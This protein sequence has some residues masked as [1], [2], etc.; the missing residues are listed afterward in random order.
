MSWLISGRGREKNSHSL[1]PARLLVHRM[2]INPTERHWPSGKVLF[3]IR[4]DAKLRIH[5]HPSPG[6]CTPYN[7]RHL[8]LPGLHRSHSAPD[9]SRSYTH[10]ICALGCRD[11]HRSHRSHTCRHLWEKENGVMSTCN[12]SPSSCYGETHQSPWTVTLGP[13]TLAL[14]NL[15]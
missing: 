3:D 2:K 11:A 5:S 15:T 1:P 6:W 7:N 9:R 8:R 14:Q 12:S 4:S 10:H 13:S